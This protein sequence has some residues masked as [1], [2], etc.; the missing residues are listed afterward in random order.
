[1]N[2]RTAV[3]DVDRAAETA[4]P[5]AWHALPTDAVLARLGTSDEGLSADEAKR[6]LER[7]GPNQLPAPPP[8][9]PLLRFL[10]QFNNTL[11]YFLLSAAVVAAIIGHVVD[12]AVIVGVVLVNAIVGFIQEGRAEEALNA[13]RD[14]IAPHARVLRGGRQHDIDARAI[15]PGD[16]VLMEAGDKAP[17]DIRLLRARSLK[18]DEAILTGESVPAEKEERPAATEA[19]LGDRHSMVFSGTLL[20]TGQATGIVVATG[21]GTEI[22]RISTMI[23]GIRTLETPLLVQINRF[24]RIFT[25]VA[26]TTAAALMAFAML[27]HAYPWAD[28]LMIVVALAVGVVPEGLPA[29][30]TITLAI[31]VRRMA[32]RNAVVR[33]LPAVETLGAV[34]VICSDKTGTL[35]KNEMTAR[36]IATSERES[37]VAGAGYAPEGVI[38]EGDT[39]PNRSETELVRAAL[40]CNDAQLVEADGRWSVLGDPMEGALVTLAMKAGLQP[41][42]ERSNRARIDEIPFDARHRFMATLNRDPA[43][44]GRIFVKGAPERVLAMCARQAGGDAGATEMDLDAAYWRK[45]IA[46]AAANG[47]RVLGLAA[48]TAPAALERLTFEDVET[49]LVFL[50]IVGF[51]D[52]PREEAMAAV[53][54]CR[55]AGIAVKMITGDHVDTAAAIAR[56]LA[57]ADDP[58]AMTGAEIDAVAD[59]EL[60]AVVEAVSVFARTSPEHKLRIVRALQNNGHVVAMTGD[61]VNDAPS[62]KQADVGIAMGRKGTEAAKEA[63]EMV[64]VDDNFASIV[65]AVHEG[66]TVFDNIRKV[67]SWTVPTNG[68]E[69]ICVVLAILLGLSLPMSPVQILWINMILTVT[70]GL[71][72]AFEPTEP[73]VM[74]RPPRGRNAPLVTGFLAWRIL[75]VSILFTIGVFGIFE[76]AMRSGQG[77]R[78]ARTM[79]VN[80]LVVMEIFYLF[81]VRYLHMTSFNLKGVLGTP[82]VLGAIG[83]VVAAQLA[84]TYAPFMHA[85]FDSAPVAIGDGVL[86]IAIGIVTMLV[87]EA[88]KAL[89]R[90]MGALRPADT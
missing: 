4:Q 32:R 54:D 27:V 55:S 59:A 56:Q 78:V 26:M 61:G 66:R 19:A 80:T 84:F 12:A 9:H 25:L 38:G 20:A 87:L 33:R 65:A 42:A 40:L 58:K 5:V 51:I 86:I 85:L 21:A 44:G 11:I 13:I 57:I 67:I 75:F 37:L 83:V 60:G 31:G 52:P 68:G 16:V 48:A 88:E 7:C 82:A 43:G 90:R 24:G 47:E 46:A 45:R 39:P 73:N 30:I 64:L 69:T 89:M 35:T 17:A 2:V 62:L 28:A 79:V 1:M 8:R 74:R 3:S 50:G 72:L 10:A 23:G 76:Y 18:V 63:A 81:N 22:G 77:E 53:A 15:V 49:G 41:E 34:S 70:L 29:V 6:R 14:M 71:V 36:R